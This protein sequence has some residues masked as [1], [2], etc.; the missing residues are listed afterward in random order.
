MNTHKNEPE[1]LLP[2]WFDKRDNSKFDAETG[3]QLLDED[4]KEIPDPTP[5]APPLGFKKQDSLAVQIRQ[6]ILSERLA[7]EAREYGGETFEEADD[8]EIGDDFETEKFSPYE[9]NF[10]PMTPQERAAL[11][12]QGRDPDRILTPEEKS[13]LIPPE[14]KEIKAK[15]KPK[16]SPDQGDTSMEEA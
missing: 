6:M 1:E 7:Q 3:E 9:A 16:P 12:T 4:G 5:M 15:A 13:S 11:A 14:Q 8:F 10:D 2:T